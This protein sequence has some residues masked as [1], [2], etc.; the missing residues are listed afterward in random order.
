MRPRI[1]FDVNGYLF[2]LRLLQASGGWGGGIKKTTERPHAFF[3]VCVKTLNEVVLKPSWVLDWLPKGIN[4]SL[5]LTG[6]ED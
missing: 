4:G 5:F 1:F 3:F 6:D 2:Q